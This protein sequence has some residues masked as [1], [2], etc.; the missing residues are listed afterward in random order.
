M[1]VPALPLWGLV[2]AAALSQVVAREILVPFG[3]PALP[4]RG[5]TAHRRPRVQL[6][7]SQGPLPPKPLVGGSVSLHVLRHGRV[8]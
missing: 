5:S 4:A 6:S 7:C 3:G 1:A 2:T 8:P